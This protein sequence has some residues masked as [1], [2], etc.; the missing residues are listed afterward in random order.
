M[1]LSAPPI[2]ASGS[3]CSRAPGHVALR[4][5]ANLSVAAGAHHRRLCRR[6][7]ER[8]PRAPD[9]S[10]AVGAAR[11]AI[12]HREPAGR[13]QQH[14]HRGGRARASGRLHAP[15]GRFAE[16]DQCDA[17]RQTQFQF[18]PRHRAGRELHARCPRHGGTSVGSGQDASGVHRLC[19]GESGQALLRFR[20]RRRDHPHHGR[21]VQDDGRRRHGA[22]ALSRRGTR[23]DRS[24]RRTGAG[25]LRQPGSVD[26]IHQE[27]ASCALWR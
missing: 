21:T 13:R 7:P 20:R 5:G 26:S 14:R 11:P 25:P 8:H 3:G 1:T 12:R 17:L 10:V 2:S 9:R 6:R 4:L 18:H 27:P 19:Q 16:R 24:A 23:A 15:P 22:C